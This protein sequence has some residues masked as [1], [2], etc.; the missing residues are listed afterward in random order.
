M[1]F[2]KGRRALSDIDRDVKYLAFDYANELPLGMRLLEMKSA[3]DALYRT[4]LIVLHELEREPRRGKITF[5]PRLKKSAARVAKNLR[6]N[7]KEPFDRA[8][9]NSKG[10]FLDHLRDKLEI[11]SIL[12]FI[13]RGEFKKGLSVYPSIT[14]GDFLDA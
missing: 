4:G 14:I 12:G 1:P 7:F 5:R 8:W 10:H 6:L 3:K 13:F 9:S 11:L 2:T